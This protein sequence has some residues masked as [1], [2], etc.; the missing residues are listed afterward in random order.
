MLARS[1][2]TRTKPKLTADNKII[3][4]VNRSQRSFSG[5][6]GVLQVACLI[7]SYTN[8]CQRIEGDV[9][10][11]DVLKT[12]WWFGRE[13][14]GPHNSWSLLGGRW[15][16]TFSQGFCI[17]PG[18]VARLCSLQFDGLKMLRQTQE[19]N[20]KYW[21]YKYFVLINPT[22]RNSISLFHSVLLFFLLLFSFLP[23]ILLTCL[24]LFIPLFAA[25]LH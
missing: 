4:S 25:L 19:Y 15:W 6:K 22:G 11:P 8:T 18:C 5:K 12:I 20:E 1:P 3:Q 14:R 17:Q 2:A 9:L 24:C 7:V 23:S 13:V 21:V 16:Q 10:R